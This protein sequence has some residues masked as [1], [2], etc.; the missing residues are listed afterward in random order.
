VSGAENGAERA[1]KKLCKRFKFKKEIGSPIVFNSQGQSMEH[2]TELDR[3]SM[4]MWTDREWGSRKS[5][6]RKRSS[7]RALQ[8]TI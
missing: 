7:Q 5:D 1:K 6:V 4:H 8:K 3:H 2:Q